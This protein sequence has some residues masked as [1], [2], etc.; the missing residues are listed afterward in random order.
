M[1]RYPLLT[2]AGVITATQVNPLLQQSDIENARQQSNDLIVPVNENELN[3]LL[4]RVATTLAKGLSS[5]AIIALFPVIII[6]F[7]IFYVFV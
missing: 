2:A 1:Y 5:L 4:V 6:A 7:L 3:D